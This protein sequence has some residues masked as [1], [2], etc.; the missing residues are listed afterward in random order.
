MRSLFAE[1]HPHFDHE[2]YTAFLVLTQTCDLVRRNNQPCKSRYINLAAV[3]PL[4]DVLF[5][6]LD[7]ECGETVVGGTK[8]DGVYA[9]DKRYRAEQLLSRILN[10]NAQAEGLFYL[11]KDAG[12]NV[13]EPSVA[14]LQVSIAVRAL[15]HYETLIKARSGRLKAEFR[16]KLGWLIGNLFSRVATEDMKPA[17]RKAILDEL[18]QP[19][20]QNA[21]NAPIW[22]PKEC[23]DRAKRTRVRLGGLS[24]AEIADVLAQQRAE[25]PKEAALSRVVQAIRESLPGIGEER[26]DLVRRQLAADPIFGAACKRA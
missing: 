22:I 26:V 20:D 24:R 7:R 9:A 3:R 13:I 2:K 1:V 11:H 5:A 19:H 14:L 15:E 6:L 12:V 18:L 8:L 25:P 17:D 16:D 4:R 23:I 10:Q 21:G